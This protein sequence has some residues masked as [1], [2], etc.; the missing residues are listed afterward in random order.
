MLWRGPDSHSKL[1]AGNMGAAPRFNTRLPLSLAPV[2]PSGFSPACLALPIPTRVGRGNPDTT[3]PVSAATP[4]PRQART[5]RSGTTC[6]TQDRA[7][8]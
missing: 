3:V 6:E 2:T 1:Q 8:S 4:I 7:N 5:C